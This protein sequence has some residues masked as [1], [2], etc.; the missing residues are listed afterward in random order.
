MV[1]KL[2]LY[3]YRNLKYKEYNKKIIN[4]FFRKFNKNVKIIIQINK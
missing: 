4:L 2:I 1:N 3:L